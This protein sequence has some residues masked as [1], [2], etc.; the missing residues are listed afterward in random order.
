[1]VGGSRSVLCFCVSRFVAFELQSSQGR[2]QLFDI[3]WACS[4][5]VAS[6]GPDNSLQVNFSFTQ[7]DLQADLYSFYFCRL[8]S[9]FFDKS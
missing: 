3:L 9:S 1:M 6:K 5:K 8:Y 2:S 7:H 4:L